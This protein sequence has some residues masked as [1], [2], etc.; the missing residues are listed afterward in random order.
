M[1]S[2]IHINFRPFIFFLSKVIKN[3]V[4][5]PPKDLDQVTK[6]PNKQRSKKKEKKRP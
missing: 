4:I 5:I 2:R 6:K 1:Y 3:Q